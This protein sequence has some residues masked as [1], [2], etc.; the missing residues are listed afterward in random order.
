ML[1]GYTYTA[2]V[3]VLS[4]LMNSMISN[5]DCVSCALFAITV[6]K[7]PVVEVTVVNTSACLKLNVPLILRDKDPSSACL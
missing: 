6:E 3:D 1:N 5:I 7:A 4:K 2:I